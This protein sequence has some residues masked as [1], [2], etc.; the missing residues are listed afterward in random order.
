MENENNHLFI[1]R[2]FFFNFAMLHPYHASSKE[3]PCYSKKKG[4]DTILEI[5][6]EKKKERTGQT[7]S[8]HAKEYVY[9]D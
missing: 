1:W 5:K 6:R 3:N 2:G 9:A 4:T 7:F 8:I